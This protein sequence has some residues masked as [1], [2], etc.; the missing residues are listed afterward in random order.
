ML[1]GR[2]AFLFLIFLIFSSLILGRQHSPLTIEAFLK[3]EIVI[4]NNFLKCSKKLVEE[5]A[6]EIM[7]DGIFLVKFSRKKRF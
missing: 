5:E 6:D 2:L 1:S 4:K 3:H 7:F